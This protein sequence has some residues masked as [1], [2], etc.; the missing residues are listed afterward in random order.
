MDQG[1]SSQMTVHLRLQVQVRMKSAGALSLL[2]ES[3]YLLGGDPWL[4]RLSAEEPETAADFVLANDGGRVAVADAVL[5]GQPVGALVATQEG[6]AGFQVGEP[7]G[8]LSSRYERDAC[9]EAFVG[10]GVGKGHW[11][12]R[13]GKPLS[14]E[15]A[16]QVGR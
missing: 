1:L 16:S 12:L 3:G 9:Y 15:P 10:G 7:L 4:P 14:V 8:Q 5:V 13:G 6:G 11:P 2:T